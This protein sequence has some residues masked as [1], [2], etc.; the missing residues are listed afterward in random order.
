MTIKSLKFS[1]PEKTI[2]DSIMPGGKNWA[3]HQGSCLNT[4][5]YFLRCKGAGPAQKVCSSKWQDA[6]LNEE[7]VNVFIHVLGSFDYYDQGDF[8]GG[9]ETAEMISRLQTMFISERDDLRENSSFA[10]GSK[11]MKTHL[12]TERKGRVG[13][14]LK[15]QRMSQEHRLSCAACD[16]DFF[17]L[18]G[19]KAT[20]VI[21]CH[22]QLPLSHED[23]TGET[24]PY[25]L[26]LL[27][28]NCHRIAHTDDKLLR[29][30][31]LR[32]FIRS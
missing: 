23:H 20:R 4:C 10:E 27:C 14:E 31:A 25:D 5:S 9:R 17:A 24:D 15:L 13:Y 16:T 12:H 18:L 2:L 1:G 8:A 19:M 29:V 7:S 32:D 26:V 22:H 28:A 11:A 21:E 6:P 3:S 30:E